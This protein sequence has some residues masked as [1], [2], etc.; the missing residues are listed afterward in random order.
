M[1]TSLPS[2]ETRMFTN[3]VRQEDLVYGLSWLKEQMEEKMTKLHRELTD[4]QWRYNGHHALADVVDD[5]RP[6]SNDDNYY[7]TNAIMSEIHECN[8]RFLQTTTT[9]IT[10]IESTLAEDRAS[11][12]KLCIEI[13]VAKSIVSA[14]REFI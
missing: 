14:L 10:E 12:R 1:E 11:M 2:F 9:R 5:C 4:L 7:A 13:A 6:V 8:L 3:L